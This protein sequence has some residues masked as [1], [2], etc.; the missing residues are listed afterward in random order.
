MHEFL[1]LI[2]QYLHTDSEKPLKNSNR[3]NSQP[4]EYEAEF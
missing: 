4:A 3:Q 1:G 2:P